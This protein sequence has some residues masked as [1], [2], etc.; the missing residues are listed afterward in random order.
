MIWALLA[1]WSAL[2]F[3]IC[4]W[5]SL[6][7][8]PLNIWL[9]KEWKGNIYYT[10]IPVLYTCTCTF[11][12]IRQLYYFVNRHWVSGVSVNG[13]QGSSRYEES[14]VLYDA[15]SERHPW[16]DPSQLTNIIRAG[17]WYQQ[18]QG[19]DLWNCEGPGYHQRWST[20]G[21]EVIYR[22]IH[23]PTLDVSA[24][25]P[26]HG[27]VPAPVWPSPGWLFQQWSLSGSWFAD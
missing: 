20:S 1:F 8:I 13:G 25:W 22:P 6:H 14:T 27:Q 12:G 5:S 3:F 26:L 9:K 18:Q 24:N 15:V 19:A 4:P 11:V 7:S 10:C 2:A 16:A 23:L 17:L 21:A